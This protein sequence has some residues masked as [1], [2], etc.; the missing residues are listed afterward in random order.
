MKV[1][2]SVD[3]EGVTGVTSWDETK[4][5]HD[6]YD[7]AVEQMTDEAIAACE[8]AIEMGAREIYVKDAHGSARNMDI[9]KFPKEVT[10]I[11][12]W[13]ECPES[14]MA[15]IDESFDAAMFIGYH[16]GHGSNANPLSHT[17]N[18][19]KSSY[20]KINDAFVSEFTINAYIAASYEVSV[21][22]LSGDENICKESKKLIEDI[23]T[24]ATKRGVGNATFNMSPKAVL[25]NI[26]LGAKEGLKNIQQCKL[27][28][29]K[30][31]TVEV[32]FKEHKDA[33]RAKFY[34]GVSLKDDYTVEYKGNNIRE[35]ITTMM[36]IL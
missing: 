19:D 30:K 3:I 15:G 17:M 31:H 6:G 4:E 22:F 27:M 32:R 28:P 1:Y 33:H 21:V 18:V 23:E 36:F 11:K 7:L 34:P 12:G 9:R 2:I 13:T 35:M 20:I 5:G 8:G 10:L 14:M 25:E 16:S 26:K 29:L 24:V